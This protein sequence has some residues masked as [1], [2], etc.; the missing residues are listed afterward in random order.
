M[1]W[2]ERVRAITRENVALCTVA[3]AHDS[4]TGPQSGSESAGAFRV[5]LF[6]PPLLERDG[7][8]KQK[9]RGKEGKKMEE[10]EGALG[11]FQAVFWKQLLLCR[12]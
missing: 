10:E 12:L 1:R 11:S 6:S 7:R 9:D 3:R 5:A 4:S 2:E 8:R